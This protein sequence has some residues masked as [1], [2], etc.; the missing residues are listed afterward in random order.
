MRAYARV[1]VNVFLFVLFSATI[2]YNVCRVCVCVCVIYIMKHGVLK[3]TYGILLSM[4]G[5]AVGGSIICV[6]IKIPRM[7]IR[8]S[9]LSLNTSG[10][11]IIAS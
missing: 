2:L 3:I 1:Y 5:R 11:H 9:C 10:V 8:I 7:T 6:L 4:N